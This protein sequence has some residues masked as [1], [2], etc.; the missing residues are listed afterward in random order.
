MTQMRTGY[1]LYLQIKTWLL[2]RIESSEW[3]E[4]SLIPSE[5]ELISTHGVSRTTIRQALQDL[6]ASGYLVRKQ[7]RGTFVAKRDQLFTSSPLYGFR[8]EMEL[9]GRATEVC[10]LTVETVNA[11][12]DVSI[13]LRIPEKAFVIKVARTICENGQ[14]VMADTSYLPAALQPFVNETALRKASIYSLLE[15]YGITIAAGEQVITAVNADAETARTISCQPG[16][17]VLY[18]ERVTRDK[19]GQPIEYSIARYRPSFYDYRV[20]LTRKIEKEDVSEEY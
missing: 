1:P 16:E 20:R 11:S 8:E 9:S 10:A 12:P 3:Q 17:A 4:G 5:S 19:G 18:V 15:S 7:G 2:E 6:V 14:P 13:H